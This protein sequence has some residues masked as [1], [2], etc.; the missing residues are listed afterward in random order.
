MNILI[1]IS[2][3][4]VITNSVIGYLLYKKHKENQNLKTDKKKLKD[5]LTEN[6]LNLDLRKGF[7]TQIHQFAEKE[8][9]TTTSDY[10]VKIHVIE[11]KKYLNGY[12]EI[13]YTKTDVLS[14]FSI[15]QYNHVINIS[16]RKF[17]TLVKTEDI[18]WL[19]EDIDIKEL[20]IDKLNNILNE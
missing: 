16:Q 4:L 10:E 5:N 13:K 2:V 19:E 18:T 11:L 17:D 3:I 6:F 8:T 9:S 15:H 12:S 7:Y 1:I 14:G 20:R